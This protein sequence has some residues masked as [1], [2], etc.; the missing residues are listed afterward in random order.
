[1]WEHRALG[2]HTDWVWPLPADRIRQGDDWQQN[3]KE[4]Y[5][6]KANIRRTAD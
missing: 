1:M 2:P 5:F 4:I 6:S 3:K